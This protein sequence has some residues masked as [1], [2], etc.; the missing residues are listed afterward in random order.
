[1]QHKL[2][3]L[4]AIS[5]AF[6]LTASAQQPPIASGANRGSNIAERNPTSSAL[7]RQAAAAP[8]DVTKVRRD[9][10]VITLK[11]G[12]EPIG[13]LQPASD[14]VKVVTREQFETLIHAVQPEMTAENQRSFA[15][16]YGRLL[17]LSDT[18][19]A[20]HL[21]DD[22]GTRAL[23]RLMAQR[24]LAEGV[25]RYYAEQF[26]HPT[27]EQIDAYYKQNNARYIEAT[28]ERIIIPRA[29]VPSDKPKPTEAEAEAAAEKLRQR[30][31]AGEDPSKLQKAAFT[32][33]GLAGGGSPNISLGPRRPGSLPPNQETVFHLKVG[34]VSSVYSD[35]AAFYLYKVVSIRQVQLS[36]VKD[37]IVKVLQQRQLQDKMEEI[38]R[39]ATP[40]LNDDYFGPATGGGQAPAGGH[41]APEASAKPGNSPD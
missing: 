24:V 11:G 15:E 12:C 22:P 9:Q 23:I 30:W 26:A 27:D 16:S 32:S 21:E 7:D 20:L 41:L 28:L 19:R 6:L 2:L 4:S 33:A 14:C 34:E 40:E 36:E 8:M 1:M 13:T 35:A 31:I 37:A 10:A 39:S 18:A 38:A 3:V 17:V 25:T 5:C 29:Q